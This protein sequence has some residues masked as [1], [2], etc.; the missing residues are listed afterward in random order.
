MRIIN[1]KGLEHSL[2]IQICPKNQGV[3]LREGK[4]L[5]RPLGFSLLK[6]LFLQLQT[7]AKQL[8]VLKL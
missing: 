3:K 2:R 6:F 1:H 7:F 4:P 8:P 5:R